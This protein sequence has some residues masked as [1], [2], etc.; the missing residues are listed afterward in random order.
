MS[1]GDSE[2]QPS[3]RVLS[4]EV[5]RRLVATGGDSSPTCGVHV[6]PSC[7]DNTL[8]GLSFTVLSVKAHDSYKMYFNLYGYLVVF[9]RPLPLTEWPL[10]Q[11]DSAEDDL[12]V[13]SSKGGLAR[14]RRS[15][16]LGY[17]FEDAQW[18]DNDLN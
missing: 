1:N 11:R 12:V 17:I 5:I 15:M 2:A 8:S 4:L 13:S 6:I 3:A 10:L 9:L 18:L 14:P 16:G 7:F